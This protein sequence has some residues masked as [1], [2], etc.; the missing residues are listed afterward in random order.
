MLLGRR[1][2]QQLTIDWSSEGDGRPLQE[3]QGS[4]RRRLAL[5][6]GGRQQKCQ[7]LHNGGGEQMAA[8]TNNTTTNH[9]RERQKQAAVGNQSGG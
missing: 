6:D 9:L 4:V 3:R 1:R 8:A 5:G 2:T 7:R